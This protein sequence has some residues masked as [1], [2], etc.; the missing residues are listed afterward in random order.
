MSN[1]GNNQSAHNLNLPLRSERLCIILFV[2]TAFFLSFLPTEIIFQRLGGREIKLGFWIMLI[3]LSFIL[4]L[5]RIMRREFWSKIRVFIFAFF[6]FLSIYGLLQAWFRP[7]TYNYKQTLTIVFFAPLFALMGTISARNQET[8]I[9]TLLYLS[10]VYVVASI[11][12]AYTG[13]LSLQPYKDFQHIFP[14]N[15]Y[16]FSYTDYQGSA[17]YVAIFSLILIFWSY[18]RSKTIF[19][20]ILVYAVNIYSIFLLFIL[21]GRASFLAFFLT[22][23]FIFLIK[24]VRIIFTLRI[25]KSDIHGFYILCGIITTISIL[26]LR[27]PGLLTLRRLSILLNLGDSS[28]R[29]MLFTNAIN[30]WFQNVWVFLF[31]IGPQAFPQ[32]IGYQSE[33]MYPHNFIFELLCEYGLVGFVLFCAP[34][35]IIALVYIRRIFTGRRR[36][37]LSENALASIVILFFIV[38]MGTGSLSSIWPLIYLI[39][40]LTPISNEVI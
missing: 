28:E 22:L 9:N 31:G 11:I 37:Q 23:F 16:K 18:F 6:F 3:T 17:F 32:A 2:F 25:K 24:I 35:I 21:G 29:V 4:V 33:G 15:W 14:P 39:F 36:I 1:S 10:G 40:V 38:S 26:V 30:L 20:R 12:S 13:F 27:N 34:I 5:F 8:V 19:A 7:P